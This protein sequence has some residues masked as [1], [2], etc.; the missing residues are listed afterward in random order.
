MQARPIARGRSMNAPTVWRFESV[1]SLDSVGKIY[2]DLAVRW[3]RFSAEKPRREKAHLGLFQNPPFE[4][5]IYEPKQK[6]HRK[7]GLSVLA[8]IVG[9]EPTKCQSQSLVP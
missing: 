9:L 6:D 3:T 4:S 5:S 1:H 7:G 8:G 2:F